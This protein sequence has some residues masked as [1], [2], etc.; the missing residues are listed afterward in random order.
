M[1]FRIKEPC[2]TTGI[3]GALGLPVA[4]VSGW[5]RKEELQGERGRGA[6]RERERKQGS[7]KVNWGR[8]MH[9]WSL[10]HEGLRHGHGMGAPMSLP[11][12]LQE[13]GDDWDSKCTLVQVLKITTKSL[14]SFFYS[15]FCYF[16]LIN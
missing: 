8:L 14:A 1:L 3:A 4:R 16:P 13:E 7:S 5:G 12:V 11:A 2:S 15:E 10:P 6:C 9:R